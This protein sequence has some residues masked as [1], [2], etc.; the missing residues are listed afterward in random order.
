M[1]LWYP[2]S[3]RKG[4]T[5]AGRA[6]ALDVGEPNSIICSVTNFPCDLSEVTKSL[7]LLVHPLYGTGKPVPFFTELTRGEMF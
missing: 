2:S 6:S 5:G 4:V 3:S 1:N 7:W